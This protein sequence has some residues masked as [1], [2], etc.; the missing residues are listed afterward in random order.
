MSDQSVNIVGMTNNKFYINY[1]KTQNDN[2]RSESKINI[3]TL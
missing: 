3:K 1:F 2:F